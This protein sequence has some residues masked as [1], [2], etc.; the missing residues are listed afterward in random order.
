MGYLTADEIPTGTTCRVL[1][2]PDSEQFVAN[3]TGALL[4]LTKASSYTL[5]GDLTTQ[6]MA[7]ANVE[8]FNKFCY[9]IGA[10]RVVGEIIPFAGNSSP[11]ANWLVCDGSRISI[12][13]Y[14]TL[15]DVVGEAFGPAADGLF[16]IPDLQCRVPVG[17]GT[18]PMASD[19][20]LG[21]TFGEEFHTL[22]EGEL[23]EHAHTTGNSATALA[24]APGELP[25]LIPNIFTAYTG[26][27]GSS[28]PH[29]NVQPSLGITYL[30]VAKNG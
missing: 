20:H 4:A 11:D 18:G 19:T 29:Y 22:V 23:A 10:C 24:L 15:W 16:Y 3:V 6:E 5:Y 8:M 2:I 7:E 14:A 9:Q 17:T 30:I 26:N 13:D 21:D 25:V 28:T 27:T 1:F 12:E